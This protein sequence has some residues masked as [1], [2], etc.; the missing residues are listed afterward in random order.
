MSKNHSWLTMGTV[1]LWALGAVAAFSVPSTA[2]ST[3]EVSCRND[4]S[5]P[6]V[7]VT[8]LQENTTKEH[9]LFKFLPQYFS[10]EDALKTCQNA[11]TNLQAVY[12]KGTSQYLTTDKLNGQSTVCA[13]ARRGVGCDHYSA[14]LLFTF[15]P[16]DNPSQALYA[17]LGNDFKQV[18]A[19]DVRTISR[20]YTDT[21]PSWWPFK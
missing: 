17:I 9:T 1:P 13:V 2:T 21:K 11:A 14:Q 15:Q 5:T 16:T 4:G 20:I 19:P 10:D 8:L 12:D 6:T 7:V 18:Q 3:V